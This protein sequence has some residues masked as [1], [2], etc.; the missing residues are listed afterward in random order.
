MLRSLSNLS[1]ADMKRVALPLMDALFAPNSVPF[2]E[3]EDKRFTP[4]KGFRAYQSLQQGDCFFSSVSKMAYGNDQGK[5][6]IRLGTGLYGYI[7]TESYVEQFV[8]KGINAHQFLMEASRDDVI[9]GLQ[10]MTDERELIRQ[11]LLAEAQLTLRPSSYAGF[12]QVLFAPNYSKEPSSN[13][14]S[15]RHQPL[16]IYTQPV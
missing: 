15:A 14:R 8:A 4:P 2:K 3:S 16:R 13:F 5:E 12:L 9:G 10:N 11:V 1:S 7:H 6:I